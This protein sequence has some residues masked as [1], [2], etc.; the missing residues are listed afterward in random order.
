MK[1]VLLIDGVNI[2]FWAYEFPMLTGEIY[3]VVIL[4]FDLAMWAEF[5]G[6]LN[7]AEQLLHAYVSDK[8]GLV[9]VRVSE[10]L[11]GGKEV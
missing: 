1:I 7:D 3:A 4:L 5:Q 6:R 8:I 9:V 10:I 2:A 11:G